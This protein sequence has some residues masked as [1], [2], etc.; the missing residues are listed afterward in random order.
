MDSITSFTKLNLGA[1]KK[2]APRSEGWLNLDKF[3]YPTTDEFEYRK[4]DLFR[5][6]WDLPDNSVDE[7]FASHIIEHIPHEAKR[8]SFPGHDEGEHIGEAEWYE[9]YWD[10]N[11]KWNKRWDEL[12]DLD[13][14]FAFFAEIWRVC[15][16][17]ALVN[18]VC[19][20][21]YT[22]GAFQDP[23]HTRYIVPP[24][25][26]YLTAEENGNWDYHLPLKFKI[27]HCDLVFEP[28]ALAQ[29]HGMEQGDKDWIASHEWDVFRDLTAQLQV[30]KE[31]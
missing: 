4:M 29:I 15:Q 14:F 30:V 7:V 13:G 9:K 25:F 5:Y 27:I 12:K 2:A 19:P 16:P 17:D 24:T 10:V 3:E 18:I 22:R 11:R 26:Y 6:P 8:S 28:L 21:G 20:F 23:T 31:H 1:G